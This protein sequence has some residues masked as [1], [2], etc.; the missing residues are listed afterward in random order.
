MVDQYGNGLLK[1]VT[2]LRCRSGHEFVGL[3]TKLEDVAVTH[4]KWALGYGL[5]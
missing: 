1:L 3:P 4:C 5:L 2:G